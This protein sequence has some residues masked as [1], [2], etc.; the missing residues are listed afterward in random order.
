MC[1]KRVSETSNVILND[2][3]DHCVLMWPY[4]AC[5]ILLGFYI[6]YDI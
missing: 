6:D 2:C 4:G 5:V 1:A 3:Y